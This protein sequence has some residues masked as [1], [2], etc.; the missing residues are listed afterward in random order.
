MWVLIALEA[1]IC[2]TLGYCCCGLLL[3]NRCEECR[4]QGYQPRDTGPTT[5][6]RAAPWETRC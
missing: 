3:G 2:F 6:P 1:V 5:A 4:E